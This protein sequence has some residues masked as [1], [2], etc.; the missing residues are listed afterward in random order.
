MSLLLISFIAGVVTVLT[1]CILPLLPVIVGGSLTSDV[2]SKQKALVVISSL[3]VS[4]LLFTFLLKVSTV[5][6]D[7]PVYFWQLLSGLIIVVI[8]FVTIFPKLLDNKVTTKLNVKSNSL[9]G[10]GEKRG[11]FFGN[12]ITGT[13]L[14]PCFATCSPTYFIVL[15][16]VLPV[17]LFVGTTY[18]IAYIIGLCLSLA[19]VVFVSQK[20]LNKLGILANPN[21]LFKKFIGILFVIVGVFIIFG[22]DKKM[23]LSIFNQGFFDVTKIEQKLLELNNSKKANNSKEN[24][25][26]TPVIQQVKVKEDMEIK[27][28]IEK[29]VS[30][31]KTETRDYTGLQLA[32][33]ISTPDGFINTDGKPIT[34]GEFKGK[35]VVLVSFWTFSCINCKRTLPYLNDWHSKYKDQGLE[36]ISIHTPE[37]SFE[38]VQK[39]VEDAVIVQNIK[40]PVVLDNDY[41]TWKAYGNQYWPRKYL[42]N[43]D[44]Y[45]IYDHVGEGAYEE[46]EVEI[47]KALEELHSN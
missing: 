12:V 36:I 7:V 26:P 13:A 11:G 35:K 23:Q 3:G 33:D 16:T 2:L 6:I 22:V 41:S 21:G 44:G 47:K 30:V 1:P 40:Y 39:N 46:T 9:L 20:I 32:P 37:F 29:S 18:I 5:F 19:V 8:G 34:I 4:I 24:T 15:A 28:E 17:S 31:S 38:R 14:G 42:I 27:K 43:K 25:I 45:I 10:K